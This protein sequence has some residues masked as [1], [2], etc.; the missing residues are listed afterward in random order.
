MQLPRSIPSGG[1]QPRCHLKWPIVSG[2]P[3]VLNVESMADLPAYENVRFSVIHIDDSDLA[4][5]WARIEEEAGGFLTS[6]GIKGLR[7]GLDQHVKT[8][9]VESPYVCEDFR[10]LHRHFYGRKFRERTSKC[11]RL[12]FFRDEFLTAGEI[13]LQGAQ[14]HYLGSAV[15][16][17]LLV[18]CIGRTVFDPI[19][20]GHDSN[21]VHLLATTFSNRIG[22]Q[23]YHVRGYPY[24][25][26]NSEATVCAH[27]TMWGV[28]RYLSTKFNLY[29]KHLPFELIEMA[30]RRNGRVV[31][32]HGLNYA[33]YSEI[34]DRFGCHPVIVSN[35]GLGSQPFQARLTKSI[36]ATEFMSFQKSLYTYIESGF[37]LIASF[38]GHVVSVVGHTSM[39]PE[40]VFQQ[41]RNQT[42]P[43]HAADLVGKYVVMDDNEFPYQFMARVSGTDE[44]YKRSVDQIRG[45]VVPLPDEVYLR[46][47]DVESFVSE[48][49]RAQPV[50]E[51]IKKSLSAANAQSPI[52]YRP[53]LATGASLK[54]FK[55]KQLKARP[56][57][58]VPHYHLSLSLPKFVWIVELSTASLREKDEAFGEILL[59]ATAGKSDLEPIFARIGPFIARNRGKGGGR[60]LEYVESNPY[61]TF[62]QYRHN[63]G[64]HE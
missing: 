27:V 32:H 54:A 50:A 8:V 60:D 21:T 42:E 24:R 17:P 5:S 33:D 59:D 22:G 31:P 38:G 2:V 49:I 23:I 28:C 43:V 53:F 57:D 34:L 6:W 3:S 18:R 1:T 58:K 4:K 35:H 52:I 26:Q 37:P 9:L 30:G 63:L 46:P 14:Q 62:R 25:S 16:E 13:L 48:F 20:L 41:V 47:Q 29:R 61:S 39:S 45:I 56:S 11:V 44:P 55:L 15:I 64:P 40:D 10:S 51:M 7:R 36:D 12:H 19:K